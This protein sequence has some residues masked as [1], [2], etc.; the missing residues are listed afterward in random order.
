MKKI[1]AIVLILCVALF[2][3]TGCVVTPPP[4]ED[5]TPHVCDYATEETITPATCTQGGLKLCTCSCGKQ[6]QAV[7][8]ML[9]HSIENPVVTQAT[10]TTNGKKVGVCTNCNQEVEKVIPAT[11][12][13]WGEW[14]NKDGYKVRF[15][16]IT[17]CYA[18]DRDDIDAENGDSDDKIVV[19]VGI[20]NG[21][22]GMEW[23]EVAA[24]KFE[25]KNPEYKILVDGDKKYT[26]ATLL[27][28]IDVLPQD[29]YVAPC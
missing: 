18:V 15:C 23:L 24:K 12:H 14:Q 13:A 19:Q 2:S 8:P 16:C 28:T 17:G 21:G 29:V 9:A 22:W 4:D 5:E 11:G 26:M 25:E 3:F 1:L 27:G 7:I 6:K 20:F 10:C